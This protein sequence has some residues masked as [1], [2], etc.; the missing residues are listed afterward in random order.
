MTL[1]AI[2]LVA[3]VL[4][5]AGLLVKSKVGLAT[6]FLVSFPP[7]KGDIDKLWDGRDSR[8]GL[9]PWLGGLLVWCTFG[10]ELVWVACGALLLFF[11]GV[12]RASDIVKRAW[13]TLLITK[14]S[15]ALVCLIFCLTEANPEFWNLA[16]AFL[17]S[18][19]FFG[20]CFLKMLILWTVH[21]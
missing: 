20:C 10:L 9:L 2:Y 6:C 3:V 16:G 12:Q 11:G 14:W 13:V 15:I 21:R 17:G 5:F 8:I 18:M 7:S 4:M 19:S 1:Y